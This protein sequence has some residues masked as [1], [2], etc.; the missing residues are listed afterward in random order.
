MGTVYVVDKGKTEPKAEH[1][2]A[3]SKDGF[4]WEDGMNGLRS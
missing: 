4:G 2:L 3:I 1:P